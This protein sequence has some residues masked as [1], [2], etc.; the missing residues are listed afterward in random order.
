MHQSSLRR[1]VPVLMLISTMNFFFFNLGVHLYAESLGRCVDAIP[2]NKIMSRSFFYSKKYHD[3]KRSVL[4][5]KP[6][7]AHENCALGVT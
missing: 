2:Q 4:K 5:A 3:P 7:F 1:F 6:D